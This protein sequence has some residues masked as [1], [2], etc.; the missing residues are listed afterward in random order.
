ME[1]AVLI[2][3]AVVVALVALVATRTGTIPSVHAHRSPAASSH[4]PA[5]ASAPSAA[6][7]QVPSG[8]GGT[9][10]CVV[11]GEGSSVGSSGTVGSSGMRATVA[12][13]RDT[14][15]AIGPLRHQVVT[16]P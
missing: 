1:I 13:A 3:V 8:G 15:R 2:V 5:A 10:S 6:I 4:A 7:D 12:T 9:A 14:S 11:V 16:A